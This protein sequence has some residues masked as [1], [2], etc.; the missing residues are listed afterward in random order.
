MHFAL[1]SKDLNQRVLT[2]QDETKANNRLKVL[3][4][5]NRGPLLITQKRTKDLNP[6][7]Q[8][9]C[10]LKE[11]ALDDFPSPPSVALSP[12]NDDHCQT[13][14]NNVYTVNNKESMTAACNSVV[15]STNRNPLSMELT[16]QTE[17]GR[18]PLIQTATQCPESQLNSARNGGGGGEH[19]VVTMVTKQLSALPTSLSE[20]N[21]HKVS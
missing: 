21:K 7:Y 5:G 20:H 4:T 19:S 12:L 2:K 14:A 8:V 11:T 17:C 13:G 3:D 16:C 15:P 10:K 1:F 6:P 18:N 9:G